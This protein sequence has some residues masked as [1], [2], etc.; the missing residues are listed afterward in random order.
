[1]FTD[2]DLE[3]TAELTNAKYYTVSDGEDITITEE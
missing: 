3:Q 1:L 2:G